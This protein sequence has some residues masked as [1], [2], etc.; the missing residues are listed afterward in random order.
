[1]AEKKQKR[2]E[3]RKDRQEEKFGVKMPPRVS[4]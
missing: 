3:E 4:K 2:K 1:M